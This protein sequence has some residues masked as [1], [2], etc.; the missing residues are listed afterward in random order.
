MNTLLI[1]HTKTGHTLEALTP[2]VETLKAEGAVVQVVLA[3]DFEPA[4]MLKYDSLV[5]CTPCWGGSSGFTGVAFPIVNALNK[6]PED[7]LKGKLCGGIAI[8]AKYGGKAT[9]AHLT[10]LLTNKGCE[11]FN[12]GPV[13][14][15]GTLGSIFK[16]PSV[17]KEDEELIKVYG[18]TFINHN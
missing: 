1:Y 16:G 13:V 11:N 8:H 14:K 6:L 10:K 5:V 12:P 17:T 15:A 9:L 2:F 7:G 3:S 4:S 18:K